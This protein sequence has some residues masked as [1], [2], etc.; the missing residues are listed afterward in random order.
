MLPPLAGT[1]NTGGTTASALQF[2]V[3]SA[4]NCTHSWVI[5]GPGGL[6]PIEPDA[7]T[8]AG[9]VTKIPVLRSGAEFDTLGKQ[10]D[11]SALL[12]ARVKFVD[13]T[14]P[15]RKFS[16]G[17]DAKT[18]ENRLLPA[19]PQNYDLYKWVK[20]ALLPL[21]DVPGPGKMESQSTDFSTSNPYVYLSA[22]GGKMMQPYV[23]GFVRRFFLELKLKGLILACLDEDGL[24][25]CQAEKRRYYTTACSFFFSD[26]TLGFCDSSALPRRQAS[27][28]HEDARCEENTLH[29][30]D[31]HKEFRSYI[32][33][34]TS[35]SCICT[36]FKNKIA[37]NTSK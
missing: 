8:S 21:F 3:S 27:L 22:V 36:C 19:L 9:D 4:E 26:S 37:T 29:K 34:S 17:A 35:C 25:A 32:V 28:L 14:N 6:F 18:P 7:T 31:V 12:D 30:V 33:A 16:T 20:E 11:L 13:V 10:R 23:S 2:R 15:G 5:S 1:T 24:A